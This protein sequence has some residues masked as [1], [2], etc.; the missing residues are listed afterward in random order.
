MPQVCNGC[1]T[2][3]K[4][5]DW[6]I[7]RPIRASPSHRQMAQ[8][9]RVPVLPKTI[10]PLHPARTSMSTNL[11]CMV[12]SVG[13]SAEHL[14]RSAFVLGPSVLGYYHCRPPNY[15][16]LLALLHALILLFRGLCHAPLRKARCS[17]SDTLTARVCARDGSPHTYGPLSLRQPFQISSPRSG[18]L[19][20]SRL[21][22]EGS[23][24]V[25]ERRRK[26][27]SS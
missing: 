3:K 22:S 4:R 21:C 1:K 5:Q 6:I 10:P 2:R 9:T 7:R 20:G 23:R 15:Q 24:R 13:A 14:K 25:S 16:R 19:H 27:W 12:L 18:G 8:G 11:S 26:A 17:R